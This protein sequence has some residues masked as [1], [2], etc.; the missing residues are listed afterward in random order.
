MRLRRAIVWLTMIVVGLLPWALVTA[1]VAHADTVVLK[2]GTYTRGIDVPAGTI[3]QGG[4]GVVFD[5]RK[6]IS[7]TGTGEIRSAAYRRIPVQDGHG[8][9]F[10]QGQGCRRYVCRYSDQAWSGDRLLRQTAKKRWVRP[11]FFYVGGGRIWLHRSDAVDVRVSSGRVFGTVRGTL[12]D[13]TIVGFS[14]NAADRAVVRVDG[15]TL[16]RVAIRDSAMV[17][18]QA[19]GAGPTLTDVVIDRAGW[20]GVSGVKCR[21]LR[22]DGVRITRVNGSRDF[23]T[24]PQSGALKTSRC[25]GATLAE[26]TVDRVVGHGLWFDQSTTDTTITGTSVRR[27]Q[28]RALF[29]E[30]S[31]GL[32]TRDSLFS[33][34]LPSKFAG[35]SGVRLG[36]GTVFEPGYVTPT[37]RRNCPDPATRL[38][39][40]AL[41][42][43]R[44]WP[45]DPRIT[46][47]NDVRWV[48]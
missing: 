27:V 23:A 46:W 7:P 30:I 29:Y 36:P 3:V 8:M 5:G 25:R 11:G 20:M 47:K 24:F 19:T 22:L 28:G 26:V 48:A 37:D 35:A 13:V 33:S 16:E 21:D 1:G 42:S 10:T 43:D 17:A 18:V 39:R 4:P 9:R 14:G 41:A 12:R 2:P 45:Y 32:Y 15:G 31:H 34:T 6:R 38:C 44:A 40:G